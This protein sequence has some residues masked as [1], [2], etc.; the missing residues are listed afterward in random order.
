MFP[1][2]LFLNCSESSKTNYIPGSISNVCI[3]KIAINNDLPGSL[4]NKSLEKIEESRNI[5]Y[6]S[7]ADKS[8]SAA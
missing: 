6:I 8:L 1:I 4:E 7:Q 3:V 2:L 5:L